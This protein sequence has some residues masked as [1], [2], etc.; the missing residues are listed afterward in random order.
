MG[1]T[2]ACA[3]QKGGVGK[4]TTVVNLASYLALAGDRVLVIDLDPQGNA[5]SGL[6]IDRSGGVSVYDAVVDDLALATLI[7]PTS[8]PRL[9]LIP[10]SIALAG[11]E[12]ELAPLEQRERRLA[13]LLDPVRDRFDYIFIDCPPSLGLLTVNALTAADSTLIPIQCE[14]YALEGLCQLLATIDLVRD[15]LN[16]RLEVKGAVLTMFDGRTNLS[17]DVADEVRTHLGDRV[18]D[19]V[20]PRNVR[21][22]E[23][24][25]HGLPIHVYAPELPRRRRLSRARRRDPSACRRQDRE[26]GRVHESRPGG[27]MAGADVRPRPRASAAASPRSSRSGPRRRPGPIEIPLDRIREN[28]RQPR[29]RMDDAAL[30]DAH[31]EHPRAR[32]DPADPRDRDDRRLPARRR[33]APRAR[34]ADGRPR[35]DSRRRSPARRSG[36][37]RARPRREP[38]ARGPRPDRRRRAPIGSSSTSSRSPRRTSRSVSVGLDRPSRTRSACSISTRPSRP[39]S[40]MVASPKATP[41]P[42]AGSRSNTRPGRWRPSSS[43]TSRFAR[44]RSS[45][46]ACGTR[47][48]PATRP[49]KAADPD[50]ERV[51]EDLRRSLGT[52]VR[53]ARSRRGGRI[54]IEYFSD[55]ELGRLYE[56]LMGGTA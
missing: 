14:Y 16:P 43:R 22:S 39:P 25:S 34:R 19:T 20:I 17:A 33:R 50:L 38:P 12:V 4:T 36:A 10:S 45:S 56:R 42:S 5:T 54:V 55:E 47:V 1:E 18:Y 28:P 3:N 37:A 48:P 49:A 26:P 6:G 27:L 46:G 23:A 31:G 30:A 15:H 40:P 32:R 21:L 51:E 2:I 7:T 9:D 29:L 52:K 8:T 35:P 24:P 53:L 11:A 13:R 41:A 44:P